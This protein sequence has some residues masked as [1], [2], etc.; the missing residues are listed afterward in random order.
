MIG[1]PPD[2]GWGREGWGRACALCGA[3][4]FAGFSTGGGDSGTATGGGAGVGGATAAGGATRGATTGGATGAGVAAGAGTG[5]GVV[6]AGC[7]PD[8]PRIAK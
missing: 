5:A 6:T 4:R 8:P 1:T 7:G 2:F 3:L